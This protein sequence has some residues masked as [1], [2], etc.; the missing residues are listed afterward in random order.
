TVY[1]DMAQGPRR[2]L[3]GGY[4]LL[5]DGSVGFTVGDYDRSRPL[6]IDPVLVFGT[7]LGGISTDQAAGIATDL[8][9]NTYLIGSTMSAAF[10][11]TGSFGAATFTQDVF[12]SKLTPQGGLIYSDLI[13]GSAADSTG[14][15]IA[16]DP[17]GYAYAVGSTAATNFPTTTGA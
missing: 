6:V 1:Q 13:G 12:V 10:P 14:L 17:G 2:T 7:Y 16:V 5:G 11:Q 3:V 9:G 15:G 4:R 8:S